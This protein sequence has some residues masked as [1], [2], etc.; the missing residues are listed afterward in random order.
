MKLWGF[1]ERVGIDFVEVEPVSNK[2]VLERYSWLRLEDILNKEWFS[3]KK[4]NSNFGATLGMCLSV[5]FG[6]KFYKTKQE[7]LNKGRSFYLGA[8]N[9]DMEEIKYFNDKLKEL[10]LNE[11]K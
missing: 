9:R 6:S 1:S 10:N 2:K 8:I 5:G 11:S 3:V 7:A 4:T